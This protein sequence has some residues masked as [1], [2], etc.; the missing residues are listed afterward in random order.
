LGTLLQAEQS[1]GGDVSVAMAHQLCVLAT[2]WH[3]LRDAERRD[4]ALEM[5]AWL[6]QRSPDSL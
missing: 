2:F 5:V 1:D 3:C 4:T 6:L